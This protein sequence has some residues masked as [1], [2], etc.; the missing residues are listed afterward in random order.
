MSFLAVNLPQQVNKIRKDSASH[1]KWKIIIENKKSAAKWKVKLE[2]DEKGG[3]IF[4]FLKS[5]MSRFIKSNLQPNRRCRVL[6]TK[7]TFKFAAV[8]LPSCKSIVFLSLNMNISH[9]NKWLF[10]LCSLNA[11]ISYTNLKWDMNLC[12]CYQKSSWLYVVNIYAVVMKDQQTVCYHCLQGKKQ[13][14]RHLFC[15][16]RLPVMHSFL[17]VITGIP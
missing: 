11:L 10:I 13:F 17:V 4:S 6:L 1:L 12:L 16:L 15:C 9:I 14:I 7:L 5:G 8:E 2:T 3:L